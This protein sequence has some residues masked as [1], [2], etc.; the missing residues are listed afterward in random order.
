MVHGLVMAVHVV[1]LV[2][3]LFDP[4]AALLPVLV[5]GLSTFTL[6]IVYLWSMKRVA[7]VAL[8]NGL[9][10]GLGWRIG[11]AKSRRPRQQVGKKAK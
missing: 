1:S 4:P 3:L 10:I 5:D 2:S 8:G 6:L 11:R 7:E 9:D